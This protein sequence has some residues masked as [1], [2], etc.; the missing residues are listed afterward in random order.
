MQETLLGHTLQD[1]KE[2]WYFVYFGLGI[3]V[4]L[5]KSTKVFQVR[6]ED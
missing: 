2:G 5:K 1:D 6:N 4:K 3:G